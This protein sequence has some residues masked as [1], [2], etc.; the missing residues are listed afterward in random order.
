MAT[1]AALLHELFTA[2]GF[3]IRSYSGRGMYGKTCLAVV[4]NDLISFVS[5]AIDSLADRGA[6]PE[7]LRELAESFR[8]MREDWLGRERVFYFPDV[9]YVDA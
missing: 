2:S 5:D 7:D 3:K 9:E 1:N 6:K 4:A 8:N